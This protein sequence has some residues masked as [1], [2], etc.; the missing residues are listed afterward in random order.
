MHRLLLTTLSLIA[1]VAVADIGPIDDTDVKKLS[2]E[3]PPSVVGPAAK[4][5]AADVVAQLDKLW[6]LRDDASSMKATDA[7]ISAGVKAF[8]NDYEVLW[9]AAR[10][11]WWVADGADQKLKKQLAKE[12]WNFAKAAVAANPKGHEGKYYTALNIGAYSQAV[13]ILKALGEGLEAQFNDHLDFALATNEAFDRHGP[14]VAK[15][16]YYWELPWPKRDL[17]KSREA[18]EQVTRARPEHL[19]A[20]LF[21]AETELKDGNAK[22]AKAAIDH[23]T[24]GSTDYDPPEGRR[25]QKWAVPVAAQIA[26]ALK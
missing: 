25:I 2:H 13:G 9:R 20:W 21:L 19:R 14:R 22:A 26:E 15:G 6:G 17:A 8:P 12:G 23:V 10:Y 4:A 16:R 7:A 18:L 5:T 11:R 1:T 3:P 24:S